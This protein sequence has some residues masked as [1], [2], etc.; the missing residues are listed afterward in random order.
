MC[1]VYKAV[2]K[3]NDSKFYAVR[4]MKLSEKNTLDKIKI[5]IALMEITKHTN[6][7]GYYETYLYMDCLFMVID[8]M[9]SGY[10]FKNKKKKS[11][12]F[13]KIKIIIFEDAFSLK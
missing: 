9:D 4:V 12:L 10:F 2:E 11:I 6:V 8:F 1:K 5:E 3:K 13:L 7:V